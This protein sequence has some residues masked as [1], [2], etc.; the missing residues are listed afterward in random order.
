MLNSSALETFLPGIFWRSLGPE[1]QA[2]YTALSQDATTTFHSYTY[3][4]FDLSPQVFRQC[5]T[6]D[7]SDS[8]RSFLCTP[9]LIVEGAQGILVSLQKSLANVNYSAQHRQASP[10]WL[11]ESLHRCDQGWIN[12]HNE[13]NTQWTHLIFR[14]YTSY[15]VFLGNIIKFFSA[16]SIPILTKKQQCRQITRCRSAGQQFF[17]KTWKNNKA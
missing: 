2:T 13:Q 10:V 4:H 8:Q 17:N 9:L 1:K 16:C 7:S 6:A 3:T 5:I 14:Q 15:F 11:T 12:C